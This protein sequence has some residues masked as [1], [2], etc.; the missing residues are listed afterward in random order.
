[1]ERLAI[2][3]ALTI[4][5]LLGIATVISIVIWK[6]MYEQVSVASIDREYKIGEM[7]MI[8]TMYGNTTHTKVY[9]KLSLMNTGSIPFSS[10]EIRLLDKDQNILLNKLNTTLINPTN[11]LNLEDFIWVRNIVLDEDL[12]IDINAKSL[13]N[14]TYGFIRKVR[15]E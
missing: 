6:Q 11:I 10:T 3:E 5:I 7:S 12:I 4:L 15:S 14:S 9:F 1:M 8:K 13:D 2:G